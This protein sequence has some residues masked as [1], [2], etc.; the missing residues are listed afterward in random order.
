MCI[1]GK[2]KYVHYS[3]YYYSFIFYLN[4]T[5]TY[6]YNHYITI[7]MLWNWFHYNPFTSI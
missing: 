7:Y 2:V 4:N 3:N 6:I 1:K 5:Y